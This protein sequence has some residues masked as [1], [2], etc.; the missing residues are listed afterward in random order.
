MKSILATV[1]VLVLGCSPLSR[2]QP[3]AAA[4]APTRFAAVPFA[5]GDTLL[6]ISYRNRWGFINQR[7]QVVI[8]P[9]FRHAGPFVEGLAPARLDGTYGYIHPDGTFAIAPAYDHA[10]PFSEGLARVWQHGTCFFIDQTGRKPF[11]IPFGAATDFQEGLARIT[12]GEGD[13][14]REGV[15][16]R[17]GAYVAAPLYRSVGDFSHGYAVVKGPGHDPYGKKKSHEVG[18][19]DRRGRLV[20]PFGK[21]DEIEDFR[22]GYAQ[23]G[24]PSGDE[25]WGNDHAYIDTTGKIVMRVPHAAL[26]MEH[27]FSEGLLGV[28]LPKKEKGITYSDVEL[29]N[30][31]DYTAFFDVK[32]KAVIDDRR[33]AYALPFGDG[34]TFAGTYFD[35]YLIDNTGKVLREES[36]RHTSGGF[37]DGLALVE[38]Q[39]GKW[40][41]IDRAG[42]YVIAPQ[43][44]LV[45]AD[46]FRQG[47][48]PVA[49][50]DRVRKGGKP[51]DD[52]GRRYHWGLVDRSGKYVVPPRF[53]EVGAAGFRHGLL[54]A[55]QDSLY[56]YVNPGG[57][58]VWSAVD[59]QYNG[60]P[61]ERLEPL[62]VDFMLR[63]YH[64][65]YDRPRALDSGGWAVSDNGPRAVRASD[66]FAPGRLAVEVRPA[67]ADTFARQFAGMKAYVYN[68]TGDTVA[69][70]AQDSRLYLKMQALDPQGQWRDIE[71][72]PSS[73]CGNSYHTLRLR[74]GAYWSLVVPRYAG[75]FSTS[76]RVAL[77]LTRPS[78]NRPEQERVV[79]SNAF[80]GSINPGQFWRKEGHI[81]NGIMDPY[82]D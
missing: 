68:T 38:D 39:H 35:W 67:E 14:Q 57:A 25:D 71:Y 66:R 34:R 81:P 51:E 37:S 75:D 41:A 48:L 9:R 77:T 4:P 50:A 74:P 32:G 58:W 64:Y 7:G 13:A 78:R 10:L 52:P 20:V 31:D 2:P 46:G 45:H 49:V 23:V 56:G 11:D 70:D 63:G 21:Y 79:Y 24:Y 22:N 73:W 12:L 55:R 6:P 1:G 61:P 53:T 59:A 72:L 8:E 47:L 44:D 26:V 30:L 43:F 3:D 16:D 29:I 5:P 36:F 82:L 42:T 33:F 28:R 80:P 76:L 62:N 60:K 19:I 54:F 17:T 18:V 65:A 27:H 69:L 15:I 40:G